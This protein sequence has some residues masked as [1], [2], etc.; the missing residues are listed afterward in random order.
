M[1]FQEIETNMFLYT[2]IATYTFPMKML[3]EQLKDRRIALGMKQHDMHMRA[4][5][6][7][8]HYQQIE[9]KGNPRLNTLTLIAKALQS[10][11]VLIPQE[12]LNAVRM[13]LESDEQLVPA[14]PRIKAF[15]T[16]ESTPDDDP[17][18]GLLEDDL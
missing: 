17:W 6:S 8:Q 3:L 13:V 14:N 4:G 12:K 7:R 16:E 15:F 1:F 18:E 11:L 9:S 2:K 5:I 10:E